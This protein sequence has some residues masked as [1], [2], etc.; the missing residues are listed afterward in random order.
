[1]SE[2]IWELQARLRAWHEAEYIK[3]YPNSEFLTGQ[4][5]ASHGQRRWEDLT[6]E[7]QERKE[8]VAYR[9]NCMLFSLGTAVGNFTSV[10][11]GRDVAQT[12]PGE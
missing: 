8:R 11:A 5:L 3:Q 10:P 9:V 1:M 12:E 7:E 4:V 2:S 6:P